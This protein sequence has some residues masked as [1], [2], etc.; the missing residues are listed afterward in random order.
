MSANDLEWSKG[1][2]TDSILSQIE[3]T[4]RV[5]EDRRAFECV[6]C[7]YA[8]TV[9]VPFSERCTYLPADKVAHPPIGEPSRP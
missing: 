8:E 9:V 6:E 4:E 5:H 3:P 2:T 1:R 7:A